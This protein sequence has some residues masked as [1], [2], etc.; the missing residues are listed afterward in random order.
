MSLIDPSVVKTLFRDERMFVSR[1]TWGSAG[2]KVFNR[3]ADG[4]I[5]VASHPL[6]P[7]V[8]FKKYSAE[9]GHREQR[10]NY[11]RRVEGADRLRTF[12][13]KHDLQH[14]VVPRKQFLE[15]PA[16]RDSMPILVVERLDLW[17]TDRTQSAYYDIDPDILRELCLV[18]FNFRGLDSSAKNIPFVPGGRIAFIDTE[19]WDRSS[20]KPYLR[21]LGEYLREDRRRLAKLIFDRLE[22]GKDID[23]NAQ[24]FV[25][26]VLKFI[27][28]LV[29]I[30]LGSSIKKLGRQ[31]WMQVLEH[32]EAEAAVT[33]ALISHSLIKHA[34]HYMYDH[35]AKGHDLEQWVIET[36][37]TI[38]RYAARLALG[39]ATDA[40]WHSGY[41]ENGRQRWVWEAK[42]P[43]SSGTCE[44]CS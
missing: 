24:N 35:P 20:R 43:F 31:G 44:H 21:H 8:L 17:S 19:H 30:R 1:Q 34:A 36:D 23:R 15:L 29:L 42:R 6:A 27:A 12:V 5:M 28:V 40:D 2:F 26:D 14:V 18:L 7:G 3:L 38:D 25:D 4:K 32:F 33:V 11:L 41:I 10:E 9:I 16:R 37:G 39:V 13:D 22:D